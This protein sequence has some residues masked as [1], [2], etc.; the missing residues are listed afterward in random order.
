MNNFTE[1][2]D[3]HTT[4]KFMRRK[5]PKMPIDDFNDCFQTAL[6]AVGGLRDMKGL[7]HLN[8]CMQFAS[9]WRRDYSLTNKHDS[10]NSRA[11][12]NHHVLTNF[13]DLFWNK[14]FDETEPKEFEELLEQLLKNTSEIPREVELQLLGFKRDEIAQ[15]VDIN[16]N[17][18]T[19]RINK[20]K[21]EMVEKLNLEVA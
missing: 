5:F 10:Y 6:V 14:M 18:V 2:F 20:F 17:T 16:R 12:F 8:I 4:W 9:R 7:L 19:F 13:D 15:M 3:Y 1:D 21:D 11:H